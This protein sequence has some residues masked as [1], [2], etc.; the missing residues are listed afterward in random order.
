MTSYFSFP[1]L[2][3]LIRKQGI[4]NGRLYLLSSLALVGMLALVFAFWISVSAPDYHEETT[5]I[6]FLFGLFI[7]GSIFASTTFNMLGNKDKGVYWLGLPAS[8]LE[9]L[10]CSLFYTTIVFSLVY[11]ASFF[12]VKA[13]AVMVVKALVPGHPGYSWAPARPGDKNSITFVL[14]YFIYVFYAAQ[15]LYLLGS[16]Y[17]SRFSF[18]ITTIIGAALIFCFVFYLIRLGKMFENANW[19]FFSVT[20]YK[21]FGLPGSADKMYSV[22]HLAEQIILFL[23]KFAWAPVFWIITWYRLKE[24]EI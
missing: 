5:Y 21:R 24:K 9:K 10:L 13:V 16:V 12:L 15:A 23:V 18:I 8:H 19:Q 6:I 4:E 11:A 22:P 2:L 14:P 20:S 3:Q 1:R 7:T 17:F